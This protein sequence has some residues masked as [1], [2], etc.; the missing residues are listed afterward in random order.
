VQLRT[1][2]RT[3]ERDRGSVVV[4]FSGYVSP[5]TDGARVNIQKLR[6][7]VWTT[8]A[9]TRAKAK[10]STRSRFKTR[11]RIHRSGEFR[12]LA[13]S[14]KPEYVAGAGRTVVVKVRR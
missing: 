3:V 13:E 5:A 6:G 7:G 10:S 1:Y 12:V 4:R 2:A 11:V 8:V 14:S 9:H